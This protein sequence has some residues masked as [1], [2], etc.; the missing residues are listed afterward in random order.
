MLAHKAIIFLVSDFLGEQIERPL[1]LLAQRHDV[2]AVTV[3]DPSET[4]CCPTSASRDSSI[5]RRGRRS[6]STRAIPRCARSSTRRRRGGG[7]PAPASA[8][9]LAID[10]IAVHTDR[11]IMDPLLRFFRTRETEDSA[12]DALRRS[13]AMVVLVGDRR[14]VASASARRSAQPIPVKAGVTVAPDTRARRRSVPRHDRHSRAARRDDRVSARNSTRA[15]RC[16]RSIR[17]P[18]ARAPTRRRS[19]STP[20]IASRR[21]TSARSRSGSDDDRRQATASATRRIPLTGATMFVKSVLPADSAQARPQAAA[22]R[23]SS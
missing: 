9:P 5:R 18:F 16:S 13:V 8:A 20:T 6:T 1:K 22:R 7:R 14:V 10:E 12:N 17:W 23:C 11:G 2:V 21:G 4:T 15:S 19:S 3:E